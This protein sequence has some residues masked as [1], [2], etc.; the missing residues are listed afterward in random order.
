MP[1]PTPPH[2]SERNLA[3]E[4]L[5]RL[6]WFDEIMIPV[7]P[8]QFTLRVSRNTHLIVVHPSR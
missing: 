2:P 7:G 8:F 3:A 6:A 5:Y 1:S 4:G